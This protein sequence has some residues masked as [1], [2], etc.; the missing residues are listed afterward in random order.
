[1]PKLGISKEGR[2]LWGSLQLLQILF[3]SDPNRV[4]QKES[5]GNLEIPK[6]KQ[7]SSGSK[8]FLPGF[9]GKDDPTT[10]SSEPAEDSKPKARFCTW[11]S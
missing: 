11:G 10:A 9:L 6:S 7:E 8:K 5:V 1:M 2:S 3:N 4:F